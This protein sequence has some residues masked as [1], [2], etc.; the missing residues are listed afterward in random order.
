VYFDGDWLNSEYGLLNFLGDGF[1]LDG[2]VS[3]TSSSVREFLCIA[4]FIF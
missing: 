2:R 1:Q 4:I 3:V